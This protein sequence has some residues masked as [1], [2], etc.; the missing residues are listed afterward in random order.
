[1]GGAFKRGALME[2]VQKNINAIVIVLLI[3]GVVTAIV[4]G[5]NDDSKE[6]KATDKTTTSETTTTDEAKTTDTTANDETNNDKQTTTVAESTVAKADNKYSIVAVKT[7]NQ[8]VNVRK[9]MKNF[10]KDTGEKVSAEQ[11]LFI[12]TTLVDTL[13]RNDLIY[14]GNVISL[15]AS[16]I[17]NVFDSAH[18][19]TDYQISLWAQYL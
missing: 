9:I 11:S 12:E 17:Q 7:D 8:T 10:M 2:Y 18:N 1:M 13:P 19:L 14:P 6:T 5:G 4:V 3:V 15:D 16:Q